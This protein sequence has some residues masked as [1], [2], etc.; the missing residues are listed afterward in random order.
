MQVTIHKIVKSTMQSGLGKNIWL[1]E[2]ANKMQ[3]RFIESLMNR[4]S[5]N[6]TNNEVKIEFNSLEEAI[7]FARKNNYFYEVITASSK[8][9]IKQNYADNFK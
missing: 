6:N 1:L 9:I 5:S 7:I 2:P 8:K 4:T 3:G